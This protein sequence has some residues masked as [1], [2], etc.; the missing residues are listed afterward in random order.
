MT[1]KKR[2]EKMLK[3]VFL[4]DDQGEVAKEWSSA[5]EAATDLGMTRQA[6]QYHCQNKTRKL[7]RY[8][9]DIMVTVADREVWCRWCKSFSRGVHD[10]NKGW[11][12]KHK[13]Q[14]NF[15]STCGEFRLSEKYI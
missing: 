10:A 7:L 5:D 11:C 14:R 15:R 4:L 6:V 8:E 3:P 1:K 2:F 12:M 13:A 9:K